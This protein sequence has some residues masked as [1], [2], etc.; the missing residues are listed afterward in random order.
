LSGPLLETEAWRV[1]QADALTWLRALPDGYLSLVL[2]SPPY[3]KARRYAELMFKRTGQA[4]VDWLRP[5]IVEACRASSGLVLVNMSGQ[6][7]KHQY[8]PIVEWLVADRMPAD[9]GENAA[10]RTS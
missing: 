5:I 2:F 4:W 3:G 6:V 9:D 1:D 10:G 7:E 8:R